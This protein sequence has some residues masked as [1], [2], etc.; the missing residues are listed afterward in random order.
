MILAGGV[1][2]SIRIFRKMLT[3][4]VIASAASSS[5]IS[6]VD[7]NIIPKSFSKDE[8]LSGKFKV[9]KALPKP[10]KLKE[11]ESNGTPRRPPPLVTD[12]IL[13]VATQMENLAFSVEAALQTRS[14]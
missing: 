8:K 2:L 1:L 12:V 4:L 5:E 14:S 11:G 3:R 13:I 6:Q 10:S 7:P 9:K